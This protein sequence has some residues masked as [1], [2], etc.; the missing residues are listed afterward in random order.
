[1]DPANHLVHL[2]NT[3]LKAPHHARNARLDTFATLPH[4]SQNVPI[5]IIA[6]LVQH[7]L[8]HAPIIINA[9]V[10]LKHHVLQEHIVLTLTPLIHA[11]HAQLA[12]SVQIKEALDLLVV[13]MG[14]GVLQDQQL[15]LLV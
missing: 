8:H 4:L 3:V 14:N 9:P 11:F 12:Q 13:K 2:V 1:M 7:L 15:V 10:P 6:L 5:T